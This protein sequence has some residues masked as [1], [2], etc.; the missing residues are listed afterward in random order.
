MDDETSGKREL[1]PEVKGAFDAAFGNQGKIKRSSGTHLKKEE[2][3]Q[4]D[5]SWFEGL[6]EEIKEE[7]ENVNPNRD[8]F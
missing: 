5:C 4:K 1:G 7:K 3:K 8:G 6:T 2:A